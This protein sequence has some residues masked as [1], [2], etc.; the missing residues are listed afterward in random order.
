M[1]RP[2][3]SEE[4]VTNNTKTGSELLKVNTT[5][6]KCKSSQEVKFNNY[7]K[8]L[9]PSGSKNYYNILSGKGTIK[10]MTRRRIKK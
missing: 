1:F 3:K 9:L 5:G 2:Q 6:S 10:Q 7:Q 4:D 8:I